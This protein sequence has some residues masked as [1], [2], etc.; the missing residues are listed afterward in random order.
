MNALELSFYCEAD[1]SRTLETVFVVL[2]A[3]VPILDRNR[4]GFAVGIIDLPATEEYAVIQGCPIVFSVEKPEAIERQ[5]MASHYG[6]L[7][8]YA[9]KIWEERINAFRVIARVDSFSLSFDQSDQIARGED[10]KVLSRQEGE[11]VLH[12]YLGLTSAKTA[13]AMNRSKSTVH[14]YRDSVRCKVGSKLSAVAL[15]RLVYAHR[16]VEE[17]NYLEP[18]VGVGKHYN[19]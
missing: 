1:L 9:F 15:A 11:V 3:L 18:R 7:N 19:L 13:N 6:G 8:P 2:K 14:A 12:T 16:A 4:E 17:M 10:I 5:Y